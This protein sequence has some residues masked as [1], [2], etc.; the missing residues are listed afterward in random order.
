[1]QAIVT[2][3]VR[4]YFALGTGSRDT[5]GNWGEPE[6]KV[7][8]YA[9]RLKQVSR[10]GSIAP[11][12]LF[13][14]ENDFSHYANPWG[15]FPNGQRFFEAAAPSPRRAESRHS[16]M[17]EGENRRYLERR[18]LGY[19]PVAE[20]NVFDAGRSSNSTV[21][22]AAPAAGDWPAGPAGSC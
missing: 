18:P 22:C 12:K 15:C 13:L 6:D 8:C 21:T 11:E 20:F 9:N 2:R 1:M 4:S 19:R 16:G 5:R 17:G 7:Y 3:G 10:N 14:T